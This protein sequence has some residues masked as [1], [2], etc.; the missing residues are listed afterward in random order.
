MRV[1]LGKEFPAAEYTDSIQ[2]RKTCYPEGKP[3][4][5]YDQIGH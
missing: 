1:T 2:M 3:L 4:V 5:H